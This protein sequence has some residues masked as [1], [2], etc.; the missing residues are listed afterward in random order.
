MVSTF[1][2]FDTGADLLDYA[3]CL[4][5]RSGWRL[6]YLNILPDTARCETLLGRG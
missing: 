4:I 1:I 2:T 5:S 6:W 3:R